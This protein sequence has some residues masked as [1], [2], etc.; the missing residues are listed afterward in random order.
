MS[1][2][3]LGRLMQGPT[4]KLMVARTRIVEV[5]RREEILEVFRIKRPTFWHVEYVAEGKGEIKR[6]F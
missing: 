1:R 2:D 4:Q 6:D 5:E 3:G